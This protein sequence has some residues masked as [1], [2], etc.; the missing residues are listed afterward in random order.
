[1]VGSRQKRMAAEHLERKL[2]VSEC[3]ACNVLNLAQSTKRRIYKKGDSQMIYELHNLSHKHDTF[4]YR[5]IHT[6]LQNND[7]K[8]GR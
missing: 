7:F 1:M 2:K 5:K 3:R 6:K 4:G 8:V